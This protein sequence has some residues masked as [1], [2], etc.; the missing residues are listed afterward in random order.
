MSNLVYA[1]HGGNVDTVI[2]DGRVLLRGGV[3]VERRRGRHPRRRRA[4]AAER[5][6]RLLPATAPALAIGVSPAVGSPAWSNDV[7]A[8]T[9][10]T[11]SALGLGCM[12]MSQ[13]YGP[14]DEDESIATLH[15]AL[16]LGITFFDTANAYGQGHN[17]RL[18]AGS[19]P[20]AATTS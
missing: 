9:V 6:R 17:E 11:V 20:P 13:S 14:A 4:G 2:V 16:E 7:W 12:G 8:P 3:F 18:S 19:S 5:R 15:R 10:L 1:A